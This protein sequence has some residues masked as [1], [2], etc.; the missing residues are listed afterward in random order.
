MAYDYYSEA[1]AIADLLVQEGFEAEASKLRDALAAGATGTEILMALR[2]HLQSI[3]KAD[4]RISTVTRT[5]ART[6]HAAVS[7]ALDGRG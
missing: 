2:W 1:R 4:L 3:S 5:R 6:L 7:A